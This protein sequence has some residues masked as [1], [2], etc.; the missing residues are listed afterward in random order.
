[1]AFSIPGIMYPEKCPSQLDHELLMHIFAI[2]TIPLLLAKHFMPF[3]PKKSTSLSPSSDFPPHAVWLN[4]PARVCSTTNNDLG[5]WYSYP[6]SKAGVNGAT[7]LLDLYL[8]T[9][10]GDNAIA[11]AYHLGTVK[12][13]LSKEFW[14]NVKKGKLFSPEFAVEKMFEVAKGTGLEGRG[15]C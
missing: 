4:M 10:S 8:R 2:N 5:G 11:I 13:G 9:R 3:L 15:K 7:K 6:A 1:M 12:T 14:G